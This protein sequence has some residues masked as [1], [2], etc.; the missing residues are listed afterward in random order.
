MVM[1]YKC[2]VMADGLFPQRK[3]ILNVLQ[4]AE[5]VVAC[6]GAAVKLLQHGIRPDVVV[7]DLDSFPEELRKEFSGRI[8]QVKDQEINDLT[9]GVRYAG[10][11]GYK[12]VLIL[13]ATG[14]REDHTLGNISLL[15]QYA[16]EFDRIEMV[17]DYGMFTPIVKTTT[18][19]SYP[20]QQISVFSL[21]PHGA[22]TLVG[23]KYPLYRHHLL[24]WWE[25]TLN[26]ALSD[27]FDII[28]HDEANI[29][30]YRQLK[31]E[32]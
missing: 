23:L 12:E 2:V 24:S 21:Y 19:S 4:E 28:L 13:G 9:K 1:D 3:E 8:Y 5:F 20:G 10:Q 14:L 32:L 6:D 27:S 30:V 11:Q 26:E 29:I 18:F 16:R 31:N 7:G 25:G 15:S 22:V 17:S